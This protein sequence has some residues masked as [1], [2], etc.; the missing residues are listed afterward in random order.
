MNNA[1]IRQEVDAINSD[2]IDPLFFQRQVQIGNKKLLYGD[3]SIIER[4]PKAIKTLEQIFE[5]LRNDYY[6]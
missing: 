2:S 1:F 6:I 3:D 4:I 5:M